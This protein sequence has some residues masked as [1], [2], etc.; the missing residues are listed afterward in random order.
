MSPTNRNINCPRFEAYNCWC[1]VHAH[2]QDAARSVLLLFFLVKTANILKTD[3]CNQSEQEFPKMRRQK[4]LTLG[5]HSFLR[6]SREHV[7]VLLP[8]KCS[9]YLIHG[10]LQRIGTEITQAA[11][12]NI[13]DAPVTHILRKRWW[14][15]CCQFCL[16]MLPIHRLGITV[17]KSLVNYHTYKTANRWCSI[18]AHFSVLSIQH[19]LPLI[20]VSIIIGIYRKYFWQIETWPGGKAERSDILAMFALTR[21]K[22]M[23][24]DKSFIAPAIHLFIN[25]YLQA[26]AHHSPRIDL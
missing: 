5:W 11:K 26:T 17:T 13:M 23:Y 4:L 6:C 9:Q 21:P 18:D 1:S 7:A 8:S 16:E 14:L 22:F 2:S 3:V 15:C 12:L 10:C 25:R 24:L 19:L 20:M